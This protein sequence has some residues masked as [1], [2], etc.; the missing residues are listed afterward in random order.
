MNVFRLNYTRNTSFANT[1]T[2]PNVDVA[3]LGFTIGCNN[4]GICPQN[5]NYKTL[6]PISFNNF[7]VGGPAGSEGL[8]ENTYQVQDNYSWILGTSQPDV[9]RYFFAE[10]NQHANLFRQ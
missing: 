7:S 3:A 8:R 1:P 6:P 5:P 9:W 2:G 10:P 4:L